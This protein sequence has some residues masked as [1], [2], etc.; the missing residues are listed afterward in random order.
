VAASD[1]K[2]GAPALSVHNLSKRFGA[3][4]AFQ[5]V[6]FKIG[7]GEVFGFLGPNGAGKTTMVRTLG[8]LL[9]PTSGSATVAG[10][11]LTPENGVE[12]RRRISIMPESPGLYLRLSVTENLQCF[13]NLYEAPDPTDRIGR[14]LRAVNLADRAKGACGTLSKGL[15]QRVALARALLSDPQV[16]FLD[17]PTAGL[18]PAATHDVHGLIAALRRRGVMIF[19]TTHRLEEAERLCDRIAI[20]NTTLRTIGRPDELRDQLFAKT[21][22]VRTLLALPRAGPGLCRPPGRRQ[23]APGRPGPLRPRRVRPRGRRTSGHPGAG[24]GRHRRAVDQRVAPLARGRLP[25][26]DRPGRRGGP[27]M[28]VSGR[29]VW[30]IFRKELREYRRT[31]NIVTAMVVLPL[32]YLIQPLVVVFALPASAAARLSHQH[33]LLYLLGIPAIV[34]AMIAAYAVV[35]ERQQGTLE[36]VLTTPIRREELLLGKA[37]AALVPSVVIALAVYAFYPTCVELFARPAVASALLRGPD[38]L[39]QVLF[40][41]PLAA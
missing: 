32:I 11:P 19:L 25:P 13:A 12:I 2:R 7:H 5:D 22:T 27:G 17:E 21:L 16:L 8:T 20:L 39:A 24:G 33:L 41:P 15:R 6:S 37:L 1:R 38:M 31:G 10:I 26:A 23:L 18:D 3:R 28:S 4:V 35:G 14:A 9:S 36:P 34:P 30:A 29:R 40:T